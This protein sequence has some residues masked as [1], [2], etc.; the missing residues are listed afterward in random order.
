PFPS[1]GPRIGAV[2]RGALGHLP[3]IVVDDGSADDTAA[4]ARE[5][6]ATV[7]EQRPN[8]GKGAALR[9]GFRR[10][11][12][13]GYAGG[14]TRDAAGQHDPAEI[15]AFLTAFAADPP[16]DLVIGRRN[17]RVMPPIR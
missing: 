4:R 7:I 11:L 8:Q 9:A 3:V 14:L 1:E 16:P 6:G 17:F 13:E 12:V 5:A 15:P 10:A 2:V